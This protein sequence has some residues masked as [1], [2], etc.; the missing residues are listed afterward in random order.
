MNEYRYLGDLSAT[1]PWHTRLMTCHTCRVQWGGCWDNFE[2]PI[3][4]EGELPWI[5]DLKDQE[6]K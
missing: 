4:G 2:C 6:G 3:C 5:D 1:P